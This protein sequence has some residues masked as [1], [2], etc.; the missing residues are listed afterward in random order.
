MYTAAASDYD[1]SDQDSVALADHRS[2]DTVSLI[3]FDRSLTKV[4]ICGF[5]QM[6][7][8]L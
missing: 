6:K 2:N 3:F 5:L 7:P 8:N 4:A 1:E